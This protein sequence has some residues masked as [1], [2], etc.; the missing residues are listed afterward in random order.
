[1]ENKL[2]YL[3]GT[4]VVVCPEADNF[5]VLS[6]HLCLGLVHFGFQDRSLYALSSRPRVPQFQLFVLLDLTILILFGDYEKL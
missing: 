2:I 3:Q 5:A 1:M 6:F 4:T